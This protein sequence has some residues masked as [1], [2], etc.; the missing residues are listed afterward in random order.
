VEI[1]RLDDAAAFLAEA[2]PLLLADEARHNLT[3]KDRAAFCRCPPA[4]ECRGDG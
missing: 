2:E 3:A 1:L 4:L